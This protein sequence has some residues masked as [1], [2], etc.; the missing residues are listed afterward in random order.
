MNSHSISNFEK[1]KIEKHAVGSGLMMC[2][3]D[4]L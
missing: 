4:F 3:V 1:L 2:W